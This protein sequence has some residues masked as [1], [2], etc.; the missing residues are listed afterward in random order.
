MRHFE[1]ADQILPARSALGDLAAFLRALVAEHADLFGEART[2]RLPGI[3]FGAANVGIVKSRRES[4]CLQAVEFGQ[5]PRL[6][7]AQRSE[8]GLFLAEARARLDVG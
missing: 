6:A 5:Q 1:L 7:T 4:N 3:G 8:F 2:S